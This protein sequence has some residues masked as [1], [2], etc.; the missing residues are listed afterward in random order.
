MNTNATKST[1]W[2][3]SR[4]IWIEAALEALVDGG[5]DAVKI[6]P[7]ASRI[8]LSRTSFYWFFKDRKSLLT[9]LLDGW[10][11][12]NTGGLIAMTEAFAESPAEAVLNV[13]GAFF[14]ESLFDSRLDFAVRGWALQ[15]PDT[16]A[17][18][19]EADDL[20][21]AALRKML[22]FHGYESNEA[23][24]RSRAIYLVQIGYISMQVKEDLTTRMKRIP[25][26]IEIYSGHTPGERELTRFYARHGYDPSIV[27]DEEKT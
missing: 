25:G 23:D 15:D 10:N 11:M 20:R 14:D 4:Q 19:N 22:I 27:A 13:I 17:R 2:R 5:L 8:N 9:A 21:L 16:M 18:V 24:V 3:G 12:K 6:Q 1:G 7:L 26:Y